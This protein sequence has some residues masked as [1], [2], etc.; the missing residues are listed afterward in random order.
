MM[1]EMVR[2]VGFAERTSSPMPS[3]TLTLLPVSIGNTVQHFGSKQT[4]FNPARNHCSSGEGHKKD[5]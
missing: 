4:S 3:V 5:A 2:E 1:G